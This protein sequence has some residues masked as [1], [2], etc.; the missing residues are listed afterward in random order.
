MRKAEIEARLLRQVRQ[1]LADHG[2]EDP[3]TAAGLI[4]GIPE[5]AA[6]VLSYMQLAVLGD[7]LRAL[8]FKL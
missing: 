3:D 8:G 7:T 6:A 1:V 5:I 2:V 4:L